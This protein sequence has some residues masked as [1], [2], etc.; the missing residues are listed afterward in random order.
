MAINSA[1]YATS[2]EDIKQRALS[3]QGQIQENAAAEAADKS[4]AD[5]IADE[6]TRSLQDQI[7]GAKGSEQTIM[8]KF[9][10]RKTLAEGAGAA[11]E[12][13]IKSQAGTAIQDTEEAGKK[14]MTAELESRRGFATNTAVVRDLEEST[15][16]R[17]RDLSKSRDELLLQNKVLQASRI[18]DLIVSEQEALTSARKTYVE[19]LLNLSNERRAQLSFETPEQKGQRELEQTRESQLD[20]IKLNFADIPGIKD[21]KS[22]E[23]AIGLAGPEMKKDKDQARRM[24]EAQINKE[25]AAAQAARDSVNGRPLPA[26]QVKLLSDA[27]FLPNVLDEL[28]EMVNSNLGLI[29]PVS[30][31]VPFSEDRDIIKARLKTAA[32]L[33]GKFME[34]GVLRLEDEIKYAAMLPQ[35]TD[36]NSNVALAKLQAVREMLAMQYNSYLI[37]FGASGFNVSGF[38]S[39]TFIPEGGGRSLSPTTASNVPTTGSDRVLT[40]PATGSGIGDLNGNMFGGLFQTNMINQ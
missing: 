30:G 22:L 27:K 9:N 33:I 11:N 12:E 16:K 25:Y 6:L 17:V 5:P 26:T 38:D 28:E 23:E 24:V 39:I 20:E 15:A 34:G 14:R 40:S 10:E 36:L 1:Q 21:V 3:I 35:L 8:D 13:L 18:D 32:Q 4:K 2:L 19:G 7:S 37:D 29:G 31:R